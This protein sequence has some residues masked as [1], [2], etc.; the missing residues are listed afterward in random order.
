MKRLISSLIVLSICFC[1]WAQSDLQPLATV[2]LNRS[3]TITVKQLKTRAEA[4]IKNNGIPELTLEQKKQLLDELINEKLLVQS[5]EKAKLVITDSQVDQAYENFISGQMGA[6]ITEQEFAKFIREQQ[7]QSV[8]EF[9]KSQTGMTLADF[10]AYI[11]NDLTVQQ[12]VSSLKSQELAAAV[13]SDSEIRAQYEVSKA[14][15]VQ[16]DM[17]QIF[18]VSVLKQGDAQA[19]EARVNSL[20]NDLKNE[21]TTIADLKTKSQAPNSGFQAGEGYV[22]MNPASAQQLGFTPQELTTF[23][24]DGEG[25]YSDIKENQIGYQFYY[26]LEKHPQKFLELSDVVQPGSTVTVYEYIRNG[27][28][29]SKQ[30]QVYTQLKNSLAQS[31]RTSANFKMEKSGSTLDK[32]LDW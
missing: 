3:E 25:T 16:P 6:P 17:L 11:K 9:M 22:G 31:L 13:P 8:D 29:Q 18:A 1:A 24:N 27:L 21:K 30:M 10:K 26:I 12:Y 7:G 28:G 15:L 20:Y 2:K 5:A 4:V 32:L 23:F 14:Q 19:A